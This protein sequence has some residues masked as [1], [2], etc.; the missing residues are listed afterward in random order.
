[1]GQVVGGWISRLQQAR[2]GLCRAGF[3]FSGQIY[4]KCD[5]LG[6]FHPHP[7]CTPPTLSLELPPLQTGWL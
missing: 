4:L 2:S 5:A 1:M 6:Y 7:Y 3:V